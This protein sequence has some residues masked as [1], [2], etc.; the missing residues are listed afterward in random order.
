MMSPAVHSISPPSINPLPEPMLTMAPA[1]Q[2][3]E[4]P[5]E[6]V[7]GV[8]YCPYLFFVSYGRLF[9]SSDRHLVPLIV[10]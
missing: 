7:K 4:R 5:S 2:R 3:A 8:D 10:C 9:H 6:L 1:R